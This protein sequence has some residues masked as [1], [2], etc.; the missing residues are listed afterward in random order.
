MT[1]VLSTKI[2]LTMRAIALFISVFLAAR[3]YKKSQ[4]KWDVYVAIIA[5]V[6]GL[7]L[8]INDNLVK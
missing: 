5:I 3:W 8:G 1:V 6:F 7:I 2:E 4:P